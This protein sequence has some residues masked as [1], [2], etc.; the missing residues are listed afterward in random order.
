MHLSMLARSELRRLVQGTQATGADVD[1]F[2]LPL[3]LNRYPLDVG[4][5]LTVRAPLRMADIVSKLR[6]LATNLTFCHYITPFRY[7]ARRTSPF[8]LSGRSAASYRFLVSGHWLRTLSYLLKSAATRTIP[9]AP[10]RTTR[11]LHGGRENLPC[12]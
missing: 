8:V 4:T 1:L 11:A 5:P 7:R 3:D 2:G 9:P 6:S 10:A 12:T